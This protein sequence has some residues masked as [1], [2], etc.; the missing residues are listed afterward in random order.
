MSLMIL[1]VVSVLFF[2][3]DRQSSRGGTAG[4]EC[5][6]CLAMAMRMASSALIR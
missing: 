1:T 5:V 6:Y 4:A 3:G 2:T